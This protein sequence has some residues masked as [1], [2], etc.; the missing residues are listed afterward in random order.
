[1][2]A[3]ALEMV[4]T[5]SNEPTNGELKGL[6]LGLGSQLT[7]LAQ[8]VTALEHDRDT[9]KG[10]LLREVGGV[11]KSLEHQDTE[12]EKQSAQLTELVEDKKAIK[13]Y[14]R[15]IGAAVVAAPGL[16]EFFQ[17]VATHVRL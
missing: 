15:A 10:D 13:T 9:M 3:G 5:M 14:A 8:R 4:T 17:W 2:S 11:H 6:I 16:W 12:L 1:M 7:A